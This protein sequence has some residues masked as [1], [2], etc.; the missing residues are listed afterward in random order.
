MLAPSEIESPAALPAA[1]RPQ[2]GAPPVLSDAG[3][4]A[5]AV[6][7][8]GERDLQ[9]QRL[10]VQR[11][12]TAFLVFMLVVFFFGVGG[13][14]IYEYQSYAEGLAQ[15]RDICQV[16]ECFAEQ[17]K[18]FVAVRPYLSFVIAR[19]LAVYMS[20][21]MIL[22]GCTFI[23]AVPE[24]SPFKVRVSK[25]GP[26]SS[27]GLAGNLQTSSPG[28]VLVTIGALL[29]VATLYRQANPAYTPSP[30]FLE[31]VSKSRTASSSP[32]VTEGAPEP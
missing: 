3:L 27:V 16:P 31:L 6:A 1:R 19:N 26:A 12:L 11:R 9:A 24:G 15:L 13:A 29:V 32:P 2:E 5:N 10:D 17:G 8:A 30:R 23:L 22:V 7:I 4:A 25:T 21:L 28:L 14:T 20:F 18:L